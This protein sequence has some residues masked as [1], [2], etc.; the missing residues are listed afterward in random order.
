MICMLDYGAKAQVAFDRKPNDLANN[1][2]ST[3]GVS[4]SMENLTAEQIGTRTTARTGM[5]DENISN[6]GLK[7]AGS[8]VL[9]LSNTSIRH[10]FTVEDDTKFSQGV[11]DADHGGFTYHT[12]DHGL[13]FEYS[14]IPASKLDASYDFT[15]GEQTYSFSVL[16]YSQMVL[17]SDLPQM[18][19]D[20]AIATVWYNDAAN[21]Y[22]GD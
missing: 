10:Y 12:K 4:Y 1:I 21:T 8:S 18:D 14:G 9:Y 16:N 11:I 2:F 20:L 17:N 22:F 6:V 7:Y 13:Y 5:K 15:I 3:Y 19:K